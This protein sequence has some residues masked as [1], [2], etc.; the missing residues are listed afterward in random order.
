MIC[1]RFGNV[2][3]TSMPLL[4][5]LRN[6]NG[7]GMKPVPLVFLYRSPAGCWPS[8]FLS[9]GFGSN[10]STCDGPP[11]RKRKM[12]RFARG[13]KC[14]P[15]PAAARSDCGPRRA[16]RPTIPKP[17]HIR[18]SICRRVKWRASSAASPLESAADPSR[19]VNGRVADGRVLASWDKSGV[20]GFMRRDKLRR[21]VQFPGR[22]RGRATIQPTHVQ[23]T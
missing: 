12:T 9:A 11:F 1:P 5:H 23:S 13:V 17:A 6:S 21:L 15:R 7:E 3:L 16:P 2:S 14:G 19:S 18:R 4:P 20:G 8:Y 22:N 10:V